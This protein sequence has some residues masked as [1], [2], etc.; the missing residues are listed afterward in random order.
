VLQKDA[1][2]QLKISVRQVKR[3]LK[4][5]RDNGASGLI[6]KHRG[7]L[8]NNR[9]PDSTK[10]KALELIRSTY[11]DFSPTFAHEKLTE[12]HDLSFSVETLRHWMIDAE[13]WHSKSIKKA[14]INP[15]RW[16]PSSL[17]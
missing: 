3:L 10:N 7:K 17:V 1:A 8:A 4:R 13:L 9:I 16:F 2:C 14:R 11:P 15:N 12:L 6:S 5:F